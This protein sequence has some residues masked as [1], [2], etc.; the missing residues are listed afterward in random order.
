M[1]LLESCTPA[2]RSAG[3]LT[4]SATALADA[5]GLTGAAR[6]GD[7]QRVTVVVG[8]GDAA[9]RLACAD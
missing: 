2:S 5:L 1:R 4:A 8:A 9:R 3:S 6:V 7:V